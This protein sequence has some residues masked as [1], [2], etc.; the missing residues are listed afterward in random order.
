MIGKH[1]LEGVGRRVG[2]GRIGGDGAG[3]DGPAQVPSPGGA[4]A[5]TRP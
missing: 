2:V 1:V 3:V 5:L 4:D